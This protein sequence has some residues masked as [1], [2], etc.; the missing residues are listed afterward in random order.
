[1]NR[2]VVIEVTHQDALGYKG[3]KTISIFFLFLPSFLPF[4]LNVYLFLR[5]GERVRQ[6]GRGRERGRQRICADSREPMR[7]SNP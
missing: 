1:M 4:F 5:E 7:G 6:Q 2:Y 3:L